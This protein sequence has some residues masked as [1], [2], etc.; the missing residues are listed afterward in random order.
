LNTALPPFIPL[1]RFM[2]AGEYSNQRQ[3]A[4]WASA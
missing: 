1:P 3:A 4:I 2:L